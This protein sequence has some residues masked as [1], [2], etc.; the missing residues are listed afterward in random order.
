MRL[1][2]TFF[3]IHHIKNNSIENFKISIS[4]L[5]VI[6]VITNINLSKFFTPRNIR[7]DPSKRC[8]TR[9]IGNCMFYADGS[10]GSDNEDK[11]AD[12]L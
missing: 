10:D 6:L 5:S 7:K 1:E 2:L 8:T 11:V 12:Y 3:T 9:G 4:K